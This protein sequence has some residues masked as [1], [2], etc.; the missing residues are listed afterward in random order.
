[1]FLCW[2]RVMMT[3]LF[4]QDKERNMEK[5]PFWCYSE[6]YYFVIETNEDGTFISINTTN[7]DVPETLKDF[8]NLSTE[9]ND[10]VFLEL[11]TQY[12][13]QFPKF[14]EECG[15]VSEV[16]SND[17]REIIES[18]HELIHHL[19]SHDIKQWA[20]KQYESFDENYIGI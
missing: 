14:F 9:Q 4:K 13:E 1:M 19:Y 12:G 5:E 3:Y 8:F 15:D 2:K 20:I 11:K 7:F 16:R 10:K 6:Y 18:L 17:P